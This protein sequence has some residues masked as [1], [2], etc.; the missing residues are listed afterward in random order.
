MNL[1]EKLRKIVSE[2][3]FSKQ[4]SVSELV[5]SYFKR[6]IRA[7]GKKNIFDLVEKLNPPAIDP[8][9]DLKDLF[10]KDQPGKYGF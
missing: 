5:E 10:Y 1:K 4:S 3:R 8:K 2:K 9:A 7:L 6:M